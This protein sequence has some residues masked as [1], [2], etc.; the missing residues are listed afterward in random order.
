MEIAPA[1]AA[2]PDLQTVTT[3]D[4]LREVVPEPHPSLWEKDIG[5]IDG[6]ART[7]IEASPFVL[8]AT[9]GPEGTCDVTP[10]GDP[11]GSV[12]VL[13]EHTLVI[14]DRRGNR[15]LD[16]FRNI[17]DNPHVGLLFVIPGRSDTVRVNGTARIVREAPF[18][19]RLTVQGV[20][21]VLALEVTVEELF[22]HCAKAFLRAGLWEPE[23]WP[24]PASVPSVGRMAKAMKNLDVAAEDIDAALAHDAE[25]NRY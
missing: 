19:D 17:L 12:L 8:L 10:R 14:A 18:F 23:S 25:H 5:R 24:D 15:R 20:R 22:L 16:A 6:S 13:D 4:E 1:P 2:A 9:S 11:A 3:L 21:P 7:F